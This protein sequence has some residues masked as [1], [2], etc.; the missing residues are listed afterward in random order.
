MQR[1]PIEE[2]IP[3]IKVL[4]E[5]M[6]RTSFGFELDDLE[7]NKI[8][9]SVLKKLK[10][11]NSSKIL[12]KNSYNSK[13][14]IQ[15][16]NKKLNRYDSDLSIFPNNIS[17]TKSK[18]ISNYSK[19]NSLEIG[20]MQEG[21]SNIINT[22]TNNNTNIN[23]GANLNSNLNTNNNLNNNDNNNFNENDLY[24]DKNSQIYPINEN[25][26]NV[27]SNNIKD[28]I[29][30]KDNR[31]KKEK[32]E[33]YMVNQSEFNDSKVIKK[34]SNITVEVINPTLL[35][36]FRNDSFNDDEDININ[37]KQNININK[38]AKKGKMSKST[39][40]EREMRN[41]QRK[42]TK[43][44]KKRVQL[45]LEKMKDLKPGPEMNPYS[46]ELIE[47]QEI[48]IPI[49]KRAAKIHSLKISK[50]I[51]NEENKK[52]IQMQKEEEELKKDISRNKIFNQEEWDNFIEKQ[53]LWK[54]EKEFKQKAE[55][56]K[57]N[58]QYKKY[59][60]KP[61]IDAKSRALI[62]DLQYGNEDVIDEVFIRLFND[63]EEHKERQKLRDD[64]SLPSFKP[65][66]SKNSSQKNLNINLK[67]PNRSGTMPLIPL[68]NND[69]LKKK[70]SIASSKVIVNKKTE[71]AKSQKLFCALYNNNIEK[72]LVNNKSDKKK[73]LINRT[74]PT[75]YT[76]NTHSN[77]NMTELNTDLINSKYIFLEN[78]LIKKNQSQNLI[79]PKKPF[80]PLN[81][82]NM[83]EKNCNQEEIEIKEK[84]R[85]IKSNYNMNGITER[86][87]YEDGKSNYDGSKYENENN[88]TENDDY[89]NL[90][91]NQ[92]DK[93][94]T[95]KILSLLNI[96]ASGQ[97]LL[98]KINDIE[99]G[100]KFYGQSQNE[101]INSDD[102]KFD[103]NNLYKLNIRDSTPQLIKQDIIL[104]NK[105]FSD[106]FDN[107][108][109][110]DDI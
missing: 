27:S 30:N 81:I 20:K 92:N 24:S 98:E 59:L 31:E 80:L 14:P 17:Y 21:N 68:R 4:A 79:K 86:S 71:K 62:K 64:Q 95:N 58:N 18:K 22:N 19:I 84:N 7:N 10:K 39:L 91:M 82:K 83:I 16:T 41:L 78:P 23:T 110:E 34:D 105:D 108:D 76:N 109:M 12:K 32:N 33:N 97:N 88:Y 13:V 49:D 107:P 96:N 46:E 94:G 26:S 61:K 35:K 3:N 89:Y 54:D 55:Q 29:E 5:Q 100:K 1:L 101:T 28:N 70:Y 67:F 25:S 77:G 48:Y 90:K 66:I 40:Y 69:K 87:N 60:F 37:N 106:F 53:Y 63:Y 74:Q 47:R 72:Y 85:I 50:I 36:K 75:Q 11:N 104:G 93:E 6:V 65:K 45:Q 8:S 99:K 15:K 56:I 102:S 103:E 2:N 51:L 9:E 57:R 43:L 38:K 52:I 44:E 42:K 73:P